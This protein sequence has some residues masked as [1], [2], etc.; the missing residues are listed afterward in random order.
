MAGFQM[1][2]EGQL[3]GRDEL[4]AAGVLDQAIKRAGLSSLFFRIYDFSFT[5]ESMIYEKDAFDLLRRMR[6]ILMLTKLLTRIFCDL[7]TEWKSVGN[8]L[9]KNWHY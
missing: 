3:A 5:R 4:L 9:A 2:T 6:P 1:S 8:I 7:P